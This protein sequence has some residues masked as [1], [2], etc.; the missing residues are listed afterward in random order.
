MFATASSGDGPSV[1]M[2]KPSVA[3]HPKITFSC[4]STLS[5]ISP[6]RSARP[7]NLS[8]ETAIEVLPAS[9]FES[10]SEIRGSASVPRF[11]TCPGPASSAS[12]AMSVGMLEIV[13]S[14][15]RSSRFVPSSKLKMR[16]IPAPKSSLPRVSAERRALPVTL[17]S[18]IRSSSSPTVLESTEPPIT[19]GSV[20]PM[21][22]SS[23]RAPATGS[24]LNSDPTHGIARTKRRRPSTMRSQTP[25]VARLL[26]MMSATNVP[27][28]VC[29]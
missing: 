13:P 17:G 3:F 1:S 23:T 18:E 20:L 22:A 6:W 26:V 24:D 5:L 15:T 28:V 29:V 10:E 4:R 16:P 7:P 11:V 14:R 19:R 21:I 8:N 12:F 2:K 25:G 9:V 27:M